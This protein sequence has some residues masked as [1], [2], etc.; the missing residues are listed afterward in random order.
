MAPSIDVP[1]P[2]YDKL[3]PHKT[4]ASYAAGHT[5]VEKHPEYEYEDMKSHNPD[6]K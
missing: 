5:F 6:V 2:Y 4:V 1:P 3:T